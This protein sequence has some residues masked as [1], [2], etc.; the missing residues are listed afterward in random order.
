MQGRI[1][2]FSEQKS[3][4]GAGSNASI[5]KREGLASLHLIMYALNLQGTPSLT[6]IDRHGYM[7]LSHFSHASD[8]MID[9]LLGT[10]IAENIE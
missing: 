1:T 3:V 8:L 4:V 5:A 9:A 7:Q 10:L 2:R 6:F